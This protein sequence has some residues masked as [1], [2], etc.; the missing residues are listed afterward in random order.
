MVVVLFFPDMIPLNVDYVT[1]IQQP[2][3]AGF[4][5]DK[6]GLCDIK[7]VEEIGKEVVMSALFQVPKKRQVSILVPFRLRGL[8]FEYFLQKRDDRAPSSPG[9]FGAFGGGFEDGESAE[10]ALRREI[11]EELCISLAQREYGF[12]TRYEHATRIFHVYAMHVGPTFEQEVVVCEGE[13]GKFLT[14][15]E[16]RVETRKNHFIE[17]LILQ[18]DELLWG[19]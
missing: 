12:F 18:M 1:Q 6:V 19:R 15:N 7:S 16:L 11:Q 14:A 17:L 10:L 5:V 9:V 8:E 13:Y 4:V 2:A 3:R